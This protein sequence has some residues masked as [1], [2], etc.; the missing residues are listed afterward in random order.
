[1]ILECARRVKKD[2]NVRRAF[3]RAIGIDAPKD[4]YLVI[5]IDESSDIRE[6]F[7]NRRRVRL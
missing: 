6:C 5:H 3:L 7:K 1:M 4:D 2:T